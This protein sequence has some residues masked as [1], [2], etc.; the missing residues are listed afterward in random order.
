MYNPVPGNWAVRTPICFTVSSDNGQT[1]EKDQYLDHY[2][3]EEKQRDSTFAYPAVIARGKDVYIT[4]TWKRQTI[5]F[6]HLV[7][8]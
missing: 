8:L 7:M 1:W 6:W 4:Y 2:P 5:S 3:A